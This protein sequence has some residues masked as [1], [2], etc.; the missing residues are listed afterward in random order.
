MGTQ[1]LSTLRTRLKETTGDYGL[2]YA[3]HYTP[4]INS[5]A[6]Q[7]WPELYR[8]IRNDTLVAGS[9]LKNGHFED[10]TSSSYP[11]GYAVSSVTAAEETTNI[12]GGSSSAK[13]TRAGTDGYM[14]CSV[15]EQP[16]LLNLMDR[17]ITFHCAV[18]ASTASQAYIEIY[19]LQAD[20]TTQTETSSAHSG[21]GEFEI[22]E[23]NDFTLNDDLVDV[24]FRFKVI[25][26]D[27]A[28][29]FDNA[30]VSGGT[31][32]EYY[33]P[34][35][36]QDGTISQVYIQTSGRKDEI[37]DDI[38]LQDSNLE[39]VNGWRVVV[40]EGTKY[41]HFPYWANE[42]KIRLIGQAPLEDNLASD[43]DTMTLD[44]PQ[45]DLLITYAAGVMYEMEAGVASADDRQRLYDESNRWFS[46]A[47]FLK[48]NLK[49]PTTQWQTR[50]E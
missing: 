11:D 22:L 15:A 20:G 39:R 38:N 34:L 47:Q 14:Y 35:D 32:Y 8:E 17:T 5:S 4:A 6:R 10:W 48:K 23:I 33:L 16:R 28:V 12:W 46:K 42:R 13:V 50:F 26:S 30:W 37:A 1:T 27:G 41:L 31:V 21:A 2:N 9:S 45:T 19:T 40:S 44:D 7:L 25:T 18:K 43:T 24:Q 3:G 29:Y 36:F 49:M